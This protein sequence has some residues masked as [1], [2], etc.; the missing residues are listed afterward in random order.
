MKKRF[1]LLFVLVLTLVCSVFLGSAIN[2]KNVSAANDTSA[3]NTDQFSS[4][5]VTVDYN[6]GTSKRY[7]I[8]AYAGISGPLWVTGDAAVCVEEGAGSHKIGSNHG[9]GR[10]GL[11]FTFKVNSSVNGNY[12]LGIHGL[13]NE[14]SECSVTVNGGESVSYSLMD[15]RGVLWN[16]TV[17]GVIPVTLAEGLNTIVLVMQNDYT[18]W[19]SSFYITDN[20]TDDSYY[21]DREVFPRE[22]EVVQFNGESTYKYGVQSSAGISGPAWVVGV[23]VPVHD[24]NVTHMLG[25]NTSDGRS[26]LQ[27]TFKINSEYAMD[28]V[29]NV[30]AEFYGVDGTNATLNVNGVES[31]INFY[32]LSGVTE[33]AVFNNTPVKVPVT[34]VKGLNTITI[35]MQQ[36]YG[37]WFGAYSIDPVGAAPKLPTYN[38]VTIGSYVSK[39]GS[40]DAGSG[41]FGLNAFDN[42]ADYGKTGGV[43]YK[44]TVEEAGNYYLHITAMAGANLANRIKITVNGEVME[45]DGKPYAALKTDAGWSGDSLNTFIVPLVEGENE[46]KIS[47]SLA[48]V[49]ASRQ[50]EVAEGTEGAVLISNWW[51]HALNFERIPN[52]ELLVDTSNAQTLFNL[53]RQFNAEGLVV[54]LKVDD[55]ITVLD[56]SQYTIDSSAFTSAMYG[57]CQILVKMNDSNLVGKYLVNVGDAGTPYEGKVFEFN[58]DYTGANTSSFYNY[59]KI[60]G[61]GTGACEGR[62]FWTV[63]NTPMGDGGYKFGSNGAGEW[64][65][66]Q[67][68]LT[69]TINSSVAGRYLFKAA[70]ETV[71]RDYARM[72]IQVNDEE[73]YDACLFY[74]S[75][76]LPYMF[77]V[78]L[79]EGLN[80]IKLTSMEQYAYWFEWFELAPI[81][82]RELNTQL[83]SNEGVRYGLDII[84]CEANDIWAATTTERALSYYYQLPAGKYVINLTTAAAGEKDAIVYVDGVAYEV[85]VASGTTS[86]PV[87]VEDGNHVIKV[88]A[89]GNNSDF[90]LSAIN[91]VK[92]IK[93]V[94]LQIDTT[95]TNLTIPYDGI[96]DTTTI[97]A[98]IVYDDESVK[99][100]ANSEFKIVQP[101]GYSTTVAG[102]YEFKVVYK[103]NEEIYAT[104]TVIVEEEVVEE[105]TPE[106]PTPEQP[107]PEQPTPGTSDEPEQKGCGGSVIA[108]IFGVLALAGFALVARKRK[109]D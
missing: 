82:Y 22:A 73:A 65:N 52:T 63:Q 17:G 66:R 101:E 32:E 41:H 50:N 102:S 108:S 5:A 92:D 91:V 1:S 11:T 23:L 29:L 24:T 100:L 39:E 85:K 48:C 64:E 78:N 103:A 21:Q 93:P 71:N 25:S 77:E 14:H 88:Y 16:D 68:T 15:T 33:G 69:L 80:T 36:N 20:V 86:V 9:D 95:N 70:I 107:T 98:Q 4:E 57:T 51:I 60:E 46:V 97:T 45:Y 19:A 67:V 47:N 74:S 56:P 54:S 53:N 76:N 38:E 79:K 10:N 75:G 3:M 35:T 30:Y 7:G 34:L 58:G 6:G 13:F 40:I 84:D 59:A 109:K 55:E 87:E 104:F 99:G 94:K 96:L 44:F 31:N 26:G 106:Q 81:E 72:N 28:A 2:A 62:L 43:T 27:L 37:M 83:K 12:F 105:P 90:G 8:Q 89:S 49:D 42:P 61:E 18:C